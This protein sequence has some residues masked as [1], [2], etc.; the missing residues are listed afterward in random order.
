METRPRAQDSAHLPITAAAA[1][2]AAAGNGISRAAPIPIAGIIN[3]TVE[4][5]SAVTAKDKEITGATNPAVEAVVT[6]R[7]RHES[8]RQ[9]RRPESR[10]ESRR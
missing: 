2:I 10:H 4:T 3:L 6:K 7:H 5:E 8:R 1:T 9:S